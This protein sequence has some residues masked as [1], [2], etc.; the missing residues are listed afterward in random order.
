MTL[1]NTTMTINEIKTDML[2]PSNSLTSTIQNKLP[3]FN[4]IKIM[5]TT[6]KTDMDMITTKNIDKDNNFKAGKYQI[7][8]FLHYILEI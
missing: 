3:N 4:N 5:A 7:N 1:I 6:S 8:C 2:L